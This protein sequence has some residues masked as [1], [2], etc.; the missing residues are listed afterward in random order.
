MYGQSYFD[1]SI[2]G[3]VNLDY[4]PLAAVEIRQNQKV[5]NRIWI[6]L[7]G[8]FEVEGIPTNKQGL[9]HSFDLKV[10]PRLGL[11]ASPFK[12]IHTT[13][14][15]SVQ[16]K[17]GK[18]LWPYPYSRTDLRVLSTE[19]GSISGIVDLQIYRAMIGISFKSI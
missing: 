8:N 10:Y 19:Q 5:V 13:V 18:G 7:S 14:G 12:W 2:A 6:S 11:T 4:N 1:T 9:T 3:G 17:N 15:T 16:S